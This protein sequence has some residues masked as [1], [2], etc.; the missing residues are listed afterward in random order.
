MDPLSEIVA[1]LRPHTAVSKPITGR[2]AWGVRYAAYGQPGFALVLAGHCWLALGDGAPLRLGEGDFLLLPATPA[3]SLSSEPGMAC[4]PAEP[5][6]EAVR[7][8]EREGEPDFAML[9]GAFQIEPAN[10]GLL[11]A[12]LPEMIHIRAAEGLTGRMA[13]IAGLIREECEADRPG[14][15][16]ILSRLLEVMLVEC[17]RARVPEQ[18]ELPA[19]LLAGLG[20]PALARVLRAIHADVAAGWTVA[21]LASLA[22]MSRSTFAARFAEA[23]GCAPIDYLM[24]WR[25][26]LARDALSRGVKSLDRLAETVGYDS[27]SAFSTAFRKRVGCSP[28]VFARRHSTDAAPVLEAEMPA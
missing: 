26:A 4:R 10:A 6:H 20:E 28:R 12:L 7:H 11:L 16:M 1:L 15:D 14:R 3:F 18:G 21:G 27:A 9:G 13:G 8:G 2:G 19:G 24:R 5:S 22:G 17:L 23:V 25:M